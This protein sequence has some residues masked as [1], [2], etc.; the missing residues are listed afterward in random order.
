ML[1]FITF[2]DDD[3]KQYM[4][5]TQISQ[6]SNGKLHSNLEALYLKIVFI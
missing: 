6:N 5:E 1:S 2:T 4:P 3:N